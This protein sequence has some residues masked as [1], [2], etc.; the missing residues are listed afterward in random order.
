MTTFNPLDPRHTDDP[1]PRLAELLGQCPVSRPFPGAKVI[2]RDADARQVLRDA[3][4]FSSRAN[5]TGVTYGEDQLALSQLDDPYHG[6][7]RA[8]VQ[9]A[10]TPRA[11]APLEPV[12]REHAVKLVSSFGADTDLVRDFTEPFP[13]M[14]LASFLGIEHSLVRQW[15][16][17]FATLVGYHA[18]PG[19]PEFRGTVDGMIAENRFP[20]FT[21]LS[22]IEIRTL[23]YFLVV[24]GVRNVTW[25]LG[26]LI[27]R[28]LADG[29]W[30]LDSSEVA[31]EESL[32]HEPPA[33]WSMR[34]ATRRC[35]VGGVQ[36]EAGERVFVVAA[37]ANRDP[38]RW[39]EPDSFRL[40]RSSGRGHL[41]FGFGPHGC[42]G[43]ALT[44]LQARVALDV[45]PDLE[46]VPG[47]TYRR[48]GDL[49]SRG[50]ASL[51]VRMR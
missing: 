27:H 12:L 26:N 14:A 11:V 40:D 22:P 24:A 41:A 29:L 37:A 36:I 31:I 18:A 32:R 42:L 13:A 17:Q 5:N 45:L 19:W 44:R 28:L 8:K 47:F 25:F 9:S 46:L 51:P 39:P 49:I 35:E 33:L 23:V 10:F 3:S 7:L 20:Q 6:Q 30:P 15:V 50:P 43:A 21:G 16:G 38:A 2:V 48:T 4:T 34:T 1:Y